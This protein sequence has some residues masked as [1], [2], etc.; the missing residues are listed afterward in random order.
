MMWH[1]LGYH[2]SNPCIAN[3]FSFVLKLQIIGQ[4]DRI[5]KI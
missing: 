2:S 4:V 5:L 3:S 1:I